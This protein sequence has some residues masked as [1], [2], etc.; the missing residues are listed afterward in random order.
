MYKQRVRIKGSTKLPWKPSVNG[1]LFQPQEANSL[2]PQQC[3][4]PS[5]LN[6]SEIEVPRASLLA[7]RHPFQVI[8]YF[9]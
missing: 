3:L 8:D 1:A 2:L 6:T 5:N 4:Y 9:L 7:S